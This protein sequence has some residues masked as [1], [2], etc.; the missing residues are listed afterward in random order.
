MKVKNVLIVCVLF[1]FMI[2][3]PVFSSSIAVSAGNGV[4]VTDEFFMILYK[5]Q[6]SPFFTTG[7]EHFFKRANFEF[8]NKLELSFYAG[9][10][11]FKNS[12]IYYT[13]D[14]FSYD[15]TFAYMFGILKKTNRILNPYWGGR[16]LLINRFDRYSIGVN[17][18]YSEMR[19]IPLPA[20][21]SG[22]RITPFKNLDFYLYGSLG[23]SVGFNR[24]SISNEYVR[25]SK[26]VVLAH[27]FDYESIFRVD[28]KVGLFF[29]WSNRLFGAFDFYDIVGKIYWSNFISTGVKIE[30][31]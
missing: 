8:V 14:T 6:V 29:N 1:F 15:F 12:L 31:M 16:F 2:K 27:I 5:T 7:F 9:D 25:G 28:R 20:V 23:V 4:S 3:T 26:D 21:F 24:L 19:I 10:K 13:D 22:V 11:Y 30:I 18:N 17:V